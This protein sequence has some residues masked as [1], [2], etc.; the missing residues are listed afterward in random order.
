MSLFDFLKKPT[1]LESSEFKKLNSELLSLE[2][3]VEL[4]ITRMEQ[5]EIKHQ[6]L[7]GRFYQAKGKLSPL[8]EEKSE[9]SNTKQVL[10][11][12]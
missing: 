11:P 9:D 12:I 3:K 10:I 2:K 7:Q 8:E 5:L 4:M 1:S 6:S